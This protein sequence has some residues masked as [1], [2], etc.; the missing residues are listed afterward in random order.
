MINLKQE[1]ALGA[2]LLPTELALKKWQELAS[3]TTVEE[4]E[5]SVTRTLPKVYL[6]CKDEISGNQ[7][8]KLKGSY[9]HSWAKNIELFMQLKPVLKTLQ[10]EAIDYRL[11]KGG[12]INM[13]IGPPGTRIMGDIDLL[14]DKKDLHKLRHILMKLGFRQMFSLKCKHVN[15]R[16]QKL[17]L[18]FVNSGSLEIDIHIVQE[19]KPRRLFQ[20]MM[21]SS[22][23]VKNFSGIS[24]LIPNK[25][26]LISHSLI[27]GH[28][29]FQD[30]DES[31]TIMDVYTLLDSQNIENALQL[32]DYLGISSLFEDYFKNIANIGLLNDLKGSFKKRRITAIANSMKD[33]YYVAYNGARIIMRAIWYSTPSLRNF[34][35]ILR[36]QKVNR[37]LYLLWV[38]TGML[39][40][41]EFQIIKRLK[42][43]TGENQQHLGVKTLRL[44]SASQWS[45]DWRFGFSVD[46]QLSKIKVKVVSVGLTNQSFLV[47]LNGK[48]IRVTESTNSGEIILELS[49]LRP[50]NEISFRLPFSGCNICSDSMKTCTLEVLS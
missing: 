45:N 2:A 29:N 33:N 31:Q 35:R 25:E 11:L 47:F 42:G 46:S 27:H 50:W 49:E 7:L 36:T 34:L 13:L 26:Q 12:A 19:R 24:V 20:I 5:H 23:V 14:I 30:E 6:N 10:E 17:E 16:A 32:A 40:P 41:L 43:F 38:Y 37:I 18:N 28:L 9:R 48:L 1:L 39:R 4:L 21:K 3:I 44:N 22:P 8:L 15:R